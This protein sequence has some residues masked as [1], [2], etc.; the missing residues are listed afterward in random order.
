MD[1]TYSHAAQPKLRPAGRM[2]VAAAFAPPAAKL[3]ALTASRGAQSEDD[4]GEDEGYFETLQLHDGK[5]DG[6]IN[7]TTRGQAFLFLKIELRLISISESI[8]VCSVAVSSGGR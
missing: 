8:S 4:D 7:L 2:L 5:F 1:T 3:T 6:V